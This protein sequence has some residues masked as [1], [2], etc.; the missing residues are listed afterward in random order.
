MH[1]SIRRPARPS[2]L[3]PS[4]ILTAALSAFSVAAGIAALAA[5]A[6][7]AQELLWP[8]G[9]PGAKGTG[10]ADKPSLT[11]YPAAKETAN[12]AAVVICPGGGYGGL[13]I[14]HE[15]HAVARW[16]N[17]LGVHAFVL[18]YR[19]GPTYRHPI[20]LG[21]ALRALRWV[22]HNA[23]KHGIDTSR[24]GILGFSAG[25]HLASTAA[26]H[27]DAGNASASDSIDRHPSRPAFQILVYPVI[28]MDA[29]FTHGG[30]RSNLLGNNP[31][32]ELVDLL[33]NEK[34]VTS[35]TPPAFV[36]HTR[37]DNVV[38]FK[39]AEVYV[40]A[41]KAAGVPVEIKVYATGPHGFGMADGKSG[42]PNI[43]SLATWTGLAA[44]WL[45]REGFFRDPVAVAQGRRTA[46]GEPFPKAESPAPGAG[47]AK[48]FRWLGAARNALGRWFSGGPDEPAAAP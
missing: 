39:N 22:R 18:K 1:S 13:A 3:L 32:Q 31:S 26:T 47:P 43:P 20:E 4:A 37:D 2:R 30:S 23:G 16:M 7:S 11:V 10:D 27:F 14:D 33:S 6:A 17:T 29:S 44:G 36:V 5:S 21:D 19:L 24:V 45:E 40:A 9:A 38:P 28:T 42:A 48:S 15:G 46:A 41:C 8:A 34:Q 12:G 35:T 25:G